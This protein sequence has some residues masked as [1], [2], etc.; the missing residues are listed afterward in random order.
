MLIQITTVTGDL[1]ETIT[2][3]RIPRPDVIIYS[4]CGYCGELVKAP[5]KFCCDSHRVMYCQ[6][7]IGSLS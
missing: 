1:V 3:E 7:Q 5:R 2:I 6:K 4:P